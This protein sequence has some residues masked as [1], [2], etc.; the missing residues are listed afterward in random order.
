[1]PYLNP[2]QRNAAGNAITKPTKPTTWRCAEPD[3]GATGTQPSRIAAR[4]EF[5]HH[6]LT[7]HNDARF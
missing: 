5:E 1:M 7:T 4:R 2:A 6:I 3:C